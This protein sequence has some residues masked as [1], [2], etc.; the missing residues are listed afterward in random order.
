M[1]G[2]CYTLGYPWMEET[3]WIIGFVVGM[4]ES[5]CAIV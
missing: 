4:V 5:W 3:E 2:Q 1:V